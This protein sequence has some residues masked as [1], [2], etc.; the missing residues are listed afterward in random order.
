MAIGCLTYAATATRPDISSAVGILSKFMSRP[1]REH[2][3]GVKRILRYIKGTVDYG[4][5]FTTIDAH[6]ILS[7]Y[8][9]ADWGGDIETRR[10]TSGYVFQIQ[11]NTVKVDERSSSS[12]LRK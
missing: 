10:S 3:Q 1:S 6:P 4:L 8:S 11:N 7:G 5:L 9:D 12:I 2:W